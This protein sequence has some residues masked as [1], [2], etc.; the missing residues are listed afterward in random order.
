MSIESNKDAA[1]NHP[2]ERRL[3]LVDSSTDHVGI[4][5][6]LRRAFAKEPALACLDDDDSFAEFLKRIH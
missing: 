5:A 2:M 3:I 4:T 1:G 6:A